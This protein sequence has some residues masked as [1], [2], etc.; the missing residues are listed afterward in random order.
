M[1]DICIHIYTMFQYMIY[2][3]T[4]MCRGR[5]SNLTLMYRSYG[6]FQSCLHHKAN[7]PSARGLSPQYP[8]QTLPISGL[9]SPYFTSTNQQIAP[10]PRP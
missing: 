6:P 4:C 3:Y 10:V 8:M 1:Y 2:N 5:H 7:F 9:S